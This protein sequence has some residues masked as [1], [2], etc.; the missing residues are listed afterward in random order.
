MSQQTDYSHLQ[1]NYED[2]GVGET[3]SL[4]KTIIAE[5][6]H[7]FASIIDDDNP[8]HLD[9]EYAKTTMFGGP[10]AHGMHTAAFF[11][12]LIATR[13]PGVK[14]IYVSQEIKFVRPV[15]IGDT[16][17]ARATVT[18]KNDEKQRITLRTT[19]QNQQ[20]EIVIDGQAVIAVMSKKKEN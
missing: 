14:G 10:I 17:E 2:I 11:T 9:P 12:T 3:A 1:R 8:V 16:I 7:K 13:L 19:V 15:R 20:G 18:A 6:V 4:S 5:D